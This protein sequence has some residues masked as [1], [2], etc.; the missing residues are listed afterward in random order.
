MKLEFAVRGSEK[1]QAAEMDFSRLG[2]GLRKMDRVRME[3][4]RIRYR[5]EKGMFVKQK[6]PLPRWFRHTERMGAGGMTNKRIYE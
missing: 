5:K 2:F 4:I 6:N 3:E 1:L